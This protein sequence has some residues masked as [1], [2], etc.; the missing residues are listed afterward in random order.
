MSPYL[1][2]RMGLSNRFDPRRMIAVSMGEQDVGRSEILS[3][4]CSQPTLAIEGIDDCGHAIG[5]VD[6][7]GVHV[8]PWAHLCDPYL[9]A[10]VFD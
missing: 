2:L 6:E 8:R 10:I 3:R 9:D 7:R 1:N 5:P 4:K